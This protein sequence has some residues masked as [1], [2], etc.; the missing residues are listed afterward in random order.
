MNSR[1]SPRAIGVLNRMI[2]T[3][4]P[5]PPKSAAQFDCFASGRGMKWCIIVSHIAAGT[6][7]EFV[8]TG[9]SPGLAAD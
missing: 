9:K 6:D 7:A 8:Q 5:K 2:V 1:S 4:W 3:L